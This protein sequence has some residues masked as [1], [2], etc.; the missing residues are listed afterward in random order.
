MRKD[1]TATVNL[2]GNS[3][4]FLIGVDKTGELEDFHV[5]VDFI[6][7]Q[8]LDVVFDMIE[9]HREVLFESA[10]DLEMKVDLLGRQ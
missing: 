2:K 8:I 9:D 4:S 7:Q 1:V 5:V 10:R 6:K 3:Y